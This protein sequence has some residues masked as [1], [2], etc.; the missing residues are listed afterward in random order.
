MEQQNTPVDKP[1]IIPSKERR[2]LRDR[3]IRALHRLGYSMD[4]ICMEMNVSKTTVFFAVNPDGRSK[5]K[6]K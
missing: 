4:Q 3:K 5:T 1:I 6:T 2:K